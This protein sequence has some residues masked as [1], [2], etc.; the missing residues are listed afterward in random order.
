M[1][2]LRLV[3]A[4]NSIRPCLF[5]R[6]GFH[7]TTIVR[8][9]EGI[10][11]NF[12]D[13]P[14][15]VPRIRRP[16]RYFSEPLNTAKYRLSNWPIYVAPAGPQ[17]AFTKRA[18]LGLAAL[19]GYIGYLATTTASV[20]ALAATLGVVPLLLP[21]PFFQYLSKPYVTRIFRLYERLPPVI[22]KRTG[23][24]GLEYTD[25]EPQSYTY[26][27]LTEDE[28]L[29]VEQ[30]GAF[31]RSVHATQIKVKDIRIVSDRMGWV[32]WEYKDPESGEVLP[33]YVADNVGGIKMDRL[34]GVIEK[35]SGIDNGRSFLD[36]P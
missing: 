10:N 26:E 25:E 30:I 6:K 5:S 16:G 32:T 29:V 28:T 35:N 8:S 21:I 18:S 27:T 19:S 2:S 12:P 7:T 14:I 11:P 24:D 20:S 9:D 13:E 1:I 4:R 36:E 33:M 17:V 22:H 31:G 23:E 34:W 15:R 3:S